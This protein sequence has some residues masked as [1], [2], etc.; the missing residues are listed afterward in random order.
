MYIIK[1]MKVFD[2]KVNVLFLKIQW[3]YYNSIVNYNI[4]RSEQ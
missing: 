1:F 4:G 3:D 2:V